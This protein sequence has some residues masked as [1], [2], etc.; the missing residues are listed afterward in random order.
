M[1]K[2]DCFDLSTLTEVGKAKRLMLRGIKSIK[3][4]ESVRLIDAV[5]RILAKN[6]VSNFN[7]PYTWSLIYIR[8]LLEKTKMEMIF[9]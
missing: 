9:T 6:I 4:V 7:I 1:K 3:S 8:T 2:N 5:G